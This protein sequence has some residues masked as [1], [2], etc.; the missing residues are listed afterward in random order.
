MEKEKVTI[1]VTIPKANYDKANELAEK[2]GSKLQTFINM[3]V[4]MMAGVEGASFFLNWI[5]NNVNKK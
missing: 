2:M 4:A 5:L 3:F 1:S